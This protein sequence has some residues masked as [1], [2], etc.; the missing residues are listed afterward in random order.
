MSLGETVAGRGSTAASSG[1]LR[2]ADWPLI[3]SAATSCARAAISAVAKVPSQIRD[4]FL[5][6]RISD[7]HFPHLRM[8]TPR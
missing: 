4:F 8:R 5:G 7:T 6:S 1:K 3:V 2:Q